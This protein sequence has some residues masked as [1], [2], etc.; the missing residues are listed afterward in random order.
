[1]MT[2]AKRPFWQI[3]IDFREPDQSTQLNCDECFLVLEYLVDQAIRG[4][5]TIFL[6]KIV[7]Q[8]LD[9]CPDCREHHIQRIKTLEKTLIPLSEDP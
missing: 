3:L 9:Q 6:R 7:E 4:A 1:M 8:H 5:D 2:S